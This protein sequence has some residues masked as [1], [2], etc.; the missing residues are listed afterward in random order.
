[1]FAKK[2]TLACL[3]GLAVLALTAAGAMAADYSYYKGKE[4]TLVIP[5]APGGGFDTYA[6]TVIPYLEK[7]MGVKIIPKQAK[8][9]GGIRGTNLIWASKPDGLTYGL[10]SIPSLVLS[11]LS[12]AEGVQ[13]DATKFTILGRASTEPRVFTV[14]PK[15]EFK[16]IGDL[17]K[18]GRVIKF[19]SQGLDEDFFTAAVMA[20]AFGFELQQIT[21][22]EGNAD[23]A[24]AV[25]KGEGDGHITAISSSASMIKDG[26]KTALLMFWPERVQGYENVP[27][28][29]EVTSGQGQDFMKILVNLIGVHR[30]FF[31]SPGIP[32]EA[33]KEFRQALVNVFA[34]PKLVNDLESKNRPVDFMPGAEAQVLLDEVAALAEEIKPILVQAVKDVQ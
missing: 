6:R 21:G 1:M 13:Y 33:T 22:Y 2:T 23:T 34:D 15:S 20:R 19:P 8:G 5:H 7:E 12:G 29:M 31:T 18:A 16:E 9:G 25:V 11:Q 27:T 32:E 24:L 14:G 10:S 28:A 30:C 3:V 4:L 26:D 17:A